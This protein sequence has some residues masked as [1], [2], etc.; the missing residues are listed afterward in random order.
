MLL[1]VM[2][3]VVSLFLGVYRIWYTESTEIPSLKKF[4]YHPRILFFVRVASV[5]S[6][7][8]FAAIGVYDV[9]NGFERIPDS[10]LLNTVFTYITSLYL[11]SSV[12]FIVVL[13]RSLFI[14]EFIN[15]LMLL[16]LV[17]LQSSLQ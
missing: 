11:L 1:H 10:Q 12:F 9:V 14:S 3:G 5:Q 4:T 17:L 6:G 16:V 7:L 13:Y 8:M 2:A 15:L